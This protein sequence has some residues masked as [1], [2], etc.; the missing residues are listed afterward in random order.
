M[1]GKSEKVPV[2]TYYMSIHFGICHGPVDAIKGVYY[3]EKPAWTGNATENGTVTIDQPNLFGGVKKEGGIQGNMD[4][5]LGGAGQI[6]SDLMAGKLGRASGL[7]C[8]GFRGITSVLLRGINRAGCYL[9]AG[10][11]YL[12]VFW[13]SVVRLPRSLGEINSSIAQPSGIVDANPAH[14]IYECLTNTDWGMGAD[15][16]DID[17]AAFIAVAQTM[18]DEQFGLSMLWNQAGTIEA[19]V[20]DI[21]SHINGSIFTHPRTGKTTIRLLRDDYDVNTLR[22]VTPDNARVLSF[23]RKAWGETTNEM[24]VTWT[25]PA[26][27]KEESVYSQDLGNIAMQG[28]VVSD[29]RN[30]YGVRNSS[31][32][33]KLCDRELRSASAPLSSMEV[34]VDRSFWDI[35]PLECVKVTWPEY[36]IDGLVMRVMKV[37]YGRTGDSAIKLSLVED[38]FSLPRVSF[39]APPG[40][41]WVDPNVPPEPITDARLFPLPAYMLVKEGAVLADYTYPETGIAV[42]AANPVSA[43]TSSFD[44]LLEEPTP[45]GGTTW[46]TEMEQLPFIGRGILPHALGLQPTSLLN[47][48]GDSNRAD[49]AV[50]AFLL[51][52]ANAT[53]MDQMEIALVTAVDPLSGVATAVKRGVLDTI[54]RA[55]AAGTPVWVI[56]LDSLQAVPQLFTDGQTLGV[57]LLTNTTLG[58]TSPSTAPIFSET[59]GAR[60]VLPLRPANVT[61]NGELWPEML[62]LTAPELTVAWSRRNRLL[63]DTVVLGWTE[64]DL[65]P[66]AGTTYSVQLYRVDTGALV[67]ETTGVDGTSATIVSPYSGIVRLEVTAVRDGLSSYQ[68]FEHVFEL[69]TSE[70]RSVEES[71]ESR[72]T[73][74]GER[75][76]LES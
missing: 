66:E 62:E 58:S 69:I 33:Q 57:K 1:G 4:I 22:E 15:P 27:E 5:L 34:T 28:Q 10:N 38:L 20:N 54:P 52:G 74:S 26:N 13:F 2:P 43:N 51:I 64:A 31:L 37:S 23:S 67:V 9:A 14:I 53:S 32:A 21:L 30:Y 48:L 47:P 39:V 8:P 68:P 3:G 25:N 11:P 71:A 12:K 59:L 40:T 29:S 36:G 61:I 42:I 72:V 76:I 50:D 75:R 16:S 6:V 60:A 19:F 73:E 44:V 35:T 24:K 49:L 7:D 65:A 45:S 41:E 70:T 46:A 56:Y 18:V 63:E 17:T 55:W